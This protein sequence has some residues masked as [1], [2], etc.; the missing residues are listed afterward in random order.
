M[1][2]FADE[3]QGL[4]LSELLP[5][6][7]SIC[8]YLQHVDM[9]QLLRYLEEKCYKAGGNHYRHD[10][11]T[12]LK[13]VVVKFYRQLSYK[14]TLLTLTDEDC[15]CLGLPWN[16]NRYVIPAHST[17]H[18]FVKYRLKE[19]GFE[20][21]MEIVG[22]IVCQVSHEKSGI[23]DSTPLEASRYDQYAEYHPHYRCNM[24]KAHIFH[25][26][27]I[28]IF[29]SF[30]EGTKSD[31]TYATD[32]IKGVEPMKPK[33]TAV[34]ADGG[35]D[36]FEIHADIHH[37]LHAKPVI[38]CRENAVIHDDGNVDR[39]DHWVNKLWKEGGL[40]HDTLKKKLE[41]LYKQGRQEQVGMYFRNQNLRDPTFD[42][43]YSRRGDC[44]RTHNNIKSIVKF[45]VR[46]VRNDSKRLY[47]LANFVI[48]QILLLGHLQN[49]IVPV[50]QLAQY[51]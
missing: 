25:L 14:G 50:Q 5:N 36:T 10:P 3:T 40:V 23:M 22:K 47:V 8:R 34:F 32:L 33:I 26:G 42:E 48:Y 37:I 15:R 7:I 19:E 30:S 28:P 4:T 20:K 16:K 43:V 24:Y 46:K 17:L 9:Y 39:I 1:V 13:L 21:I 51:F 12:M 41:F 27:D 18:H 29:C 2:F 49:K 38:D 44:E 35:Y 45:D 31:L 6:R 11:L